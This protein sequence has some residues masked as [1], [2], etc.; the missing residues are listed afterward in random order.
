MS[1]ARANQAP[2]LIPI[3]LQQC[4]IETVMFTQRI[5]LERKAC[6]YFAGY[7]MPWRMQHLRIGVAL[8]K[9]LHGVVSL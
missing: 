7:Q 4:V 1:K 8:K 2:S 9:R 3:L 5:V 6:G